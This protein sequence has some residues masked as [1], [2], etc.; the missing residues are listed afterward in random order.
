MT[1]NRHLFTSES[2][3]DGHPDKIA[4]QISDAILDAIITKDPDA[5]VACETTV[6]TGLVLVAG[7]ITTSVYVDIPKIVRDT[8]K[9]IGYTR[10]K[11]GFD[12]DTCA[13]L[14]AIDEQSPDIAQGVNEA[15]ESR[16]GAEHDAAIEAI[17]AGDQGL[18][19]GFATDETEELMPLPIFLAHGLA[20][21]L[22]ELR[23]TKKLD[24]LRPDAKTQVTVEYDEQNR[25]VRIDTIVVSTQHHPDIT[26]EQ[27]AKDLHTYLFPEVI[28]ASFLDEDTKYFI[29][30]TGRFVIGGPLG[31]AGLTGRKIIVDTYG[32]YARHGGGAF[33]GKDP[34]KVD[35]S[36]AY[37]ARY[38][39]KNIVAAGL[40][41]KV[42]VQLAYAIG[43]AH[44]VSIS[45]D[46]YGTSAFSE[47]E[48]IDGV[49]ALFDLRPAGI[50]HMLD[51]RRP[52]YR[53]TAAF[54][55]FGRSDLDLPWE[56]TDKAEA[57]QKLVTK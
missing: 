40:A 45:I 49:N 27:I 20:R 16:S 31:D 21:K 22:T 28:D 4:D 37:A 36:G 53:Q 56:R 39:A 38:V 46:T 24:Y 47:Q 54:G 13:V 9:E 14:T 15:L 55:H 23:K 10:A 52:I 41:K 19:F 25:P 17:G 51:L 26:Q 29:N 34:T 18:M 3:S 7:E 43:V 11:Y 48:L 2:V 35:R 5:R 1:K 42:E 33:S 8:I 6:T 30:P 12:A 57:L 44:P 32:G 50:I